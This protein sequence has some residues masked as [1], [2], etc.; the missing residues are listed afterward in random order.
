[1]A[2]RQVPEAMGRQQYV[3]TATNNLALMLS[4]SLEQMQ[5]QMQ[6]KASGSG[7]GKC[8]K[9]GGSGSG[10][11][12]KPSAAQM[13]KMQEQINQQIEKLKSQLE[14]EKAQQTG[15]KKD[16]NKPGEKGQKG[17]GGQ[18]GGNG[19]S[20]Q[21]AKLAAQQEAL[22]RAVQQQSDLLNKDGKQGNGALQK[23]AE[24]M[25][26]TESDIVNKRITQET[27]R[28]QQEILTRLLEAENAE[29][30]RELD[31][32]RESNEAKKQLFG[33]PNQF[34]EYKLL[35]QKEAEILK[36][37]PPALTPFYKNK[38]NNYFN[39]FSK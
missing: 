5:Q 29:R 35:K 33:N 26:Q 27:I 37:V 6:M 16:G 31:N 17:S 21:L 18:M 8:K 23:L 32:K 38:V 1:M 3:M 7:K 14:K 19:T 10:K 4:E 22:R 28:R 39:S 12:S 24:K 11:G 9:P 36:A 20:E 15:G 13:K 25:E 34:F 2:E 30:E